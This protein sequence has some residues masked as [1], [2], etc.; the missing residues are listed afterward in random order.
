MAGV[1]PP[2]TGYLAVK[3]DRRLKSTAGVPPPT[4]G[5]LAVKF[6]RRLKSTAG[7]WGGGLGWGVGVGMVCAISLPSIFTLCDFVACFAGQFLRLRDPCF[8]GNAAI[9][10]W[11]SCGWCS[12]RT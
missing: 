11:L 7:G 2:T 6:D 4:T 8:F 3:F 9:M 12:N 1:P 10:L 5:Y